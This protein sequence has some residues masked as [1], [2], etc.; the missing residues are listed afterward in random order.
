MALNRNKAIFLP[1]K[2]KKKCCLHCI[3]LKWFRLDACSMHVQFYPILFL[4]GYL[5]IPLVHNPS[6]KI[7]G[8]YPYH[9][10]QLTV[11]NRLKWLSRD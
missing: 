8:V 9:I 4:N 1:Q 10:A 2:K 7:P 3:M 11:R 6:P 5:R